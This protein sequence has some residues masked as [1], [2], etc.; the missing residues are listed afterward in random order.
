MTTRLPSLCDSC[1]H[2]GPIDGW[3]G[4]FPCNAFP[5]GVPGE[6]VDMEFDHRQPHPL[7]NGITY[8]MDPDKSN[9]LETHLE[10]KNSIDLNFGVGE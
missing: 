5:S 4:N 2:Q 10:I 9:T 3:T 6:I 7:D 1:I 8:T